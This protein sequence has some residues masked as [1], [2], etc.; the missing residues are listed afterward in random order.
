MIEPGKRPRVTLTPTLVL[1]DGKGRAYRAA[2]SETGGKKRQ[3]SQYKT[4]FPVRRFGARRLFSGLSNERPIHCAHLPRC[5]PRFSSEGL[6]LRQI[7]FLAN[8]LRTLS[9][10][11]ALFDLRE[12]FG[13]IAPLTLKGLDG[14]RSPWLGTTIR[15]SIFS[16]RSNTRTQFA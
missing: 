4:A 5:P 11:N 12:H 14:P 3:P 1:K 7:D 10:A 16:N 13:E 9:D 15:A 2:Q 6:I 8:L